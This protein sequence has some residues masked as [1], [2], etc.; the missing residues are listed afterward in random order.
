MS[1]LGFPDSRDCDWTRGDRVEDSLEDLIGHGM[2]AA[3]MF[4]PMADEYSKI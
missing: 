4:V 1:H 3:G 2:G